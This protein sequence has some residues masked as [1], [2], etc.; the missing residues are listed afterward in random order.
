M[1]AILFI[2]AVAFILVPLSSCL[3]D[4]TCTCNSNNQG[5]A[6][7][8]YPLYGVT[9]KGAIN[10]CNNDGAALDS[11]GVSVWSCSL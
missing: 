8:S 2:I 4:W 1:K 9:K 11:M 10:A 3:K 5:T 6:P 7:V